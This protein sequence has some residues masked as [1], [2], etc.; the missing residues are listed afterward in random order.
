VR[1]QP[2]LSGG[3]AGGDDPSA[4]ESIVEIRVLAIDESPDEAGSEASEA[5][6]RGDIADH[7]AGE[8]QP[9]A[10]DGN[11]PEAPRFH[12]ESLPAARPLPREVNA[13]GKDQVKLLN[14]A[15]QH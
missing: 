9:L 11:D 4:C 3:G 6:Q 12:R 5:D 13:C 7:G 15:Y 10:G 8:W 14:V 2:Q 1:K